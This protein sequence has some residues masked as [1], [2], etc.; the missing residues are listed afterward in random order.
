MLIAVGN[1][2]K[3]YVE[4]AKSR[5]MKNVFHFDTVDDAVTCLSQSVA[6]GDVVLVKGSRGMHMERVVDAL[7]H[8]VPVLRF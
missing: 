4:G 6:E 2:A 8:M 5:G 7:L 3:K 1:E